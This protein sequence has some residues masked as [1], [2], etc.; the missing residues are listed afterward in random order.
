MNIFED[1]LK[2]RRNGTPRGLYS[3]CSS[4]P[5][6]LAAA[7]DRTARSGHPVLIEATANQV[8]QYGGYTGMTPA[9]FAG[10]LAARAAAAGVPDGLIL[11][12]GDHLGPF[13]WRAKHAAEAMNEAIVLV[14]AFVAAGAG[15][16]HLDASMP[17]ADDPAGALEPAV[18]ASRAADLCAAAEEEFGHYRVAHPHAA[19]PVYVIGTEVPVPGGFAGDETGEGP[20]P[21][22]PEDLHATINIHQEAFMR[23]GLTRAW[24]RVIA[25]VVQPGLE[26]DAMRVYPYRPERAQSLIS[27][28]QKYPD[29]VLEGHSTDYQ[30]ETVLKQLVRDGIAILK[31]GPALTFALREALFGLAHLDAEL[32]GNAGKPDLLVTVEQIMGE[33]PESWK[34]Y[35]GKDDRIAILFGYS[36][37]IRYYWDQPV[38][39][40]AVSRLMES[41]SHRSIPAQLLSQ[42]V[43]H[44]DQEYLSGKIDVRC[45]PAAVVDSELARYEQ[46]CFPE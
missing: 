46:A 5:E 8:N 31:V 40:A 21:T 35:Y 17:L 42:Y 27:A 11:F 7:L 10:S 12:G 34:D 44:L 38:V 19:E 36:D 41:L 18:A 4:H 29:L 28:I 30:T 26:F 39:V 20:V 9:D 32:S 2:A 22:R 15:K 1:M 43:P 3:V 45:I 37:R 16:I 33:K 14:R 6:V 24:Q 25:V 23:R 13:P